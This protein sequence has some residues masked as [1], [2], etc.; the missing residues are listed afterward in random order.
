LK[1]HWINTMNFSY[2]IIIGRGAITQIGRIIREKNLIHGEKVALITSERI[3]DYWGDEVS[4]SFSDTGLDIRLVKIPDGEEAKEL[5]TLGEIYGELVRFG[6]HRDGLIVALGGGSV[7]DVAGFAAST[8]LRGVDYINVPTTFLAQLDSCVGGKTGINH[9]GG[10]NLV[11]TFWQPK[12]A[13]VDPDIIETLEPRQVLSGLAEAVKAA[14]IADESLFDFIENKFDALLAMEDPDALDEVIERTLL[15]KAQVV[16]ADE[17]ETHGYRVLL[18][19]GHTFGHAY[20]AL[21]REQ[22]QPVSHGEA[23]ALGMLTESR[24]ANLLGILGEFEETR[25]VGLCRKIIDPSLAT[26]LQWKDVQM[27]LNI[28]KKARDE[29]IYFALP[30]SIGSVEV[31]GNVDEAQMRDAMGQ[32]PLTH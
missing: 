25:I 20:E 17:N 22:G 1:E 3:F 12:G 24:L 31:I 21:L 4:K 6:L 32:T 9:E 26:S 27:L 11:G 15:I 16:E 23:V 14:V 2:P 13:I 28:D 5:R 8:Y 19:F 18:N 30:T 29:G 7:S 10:K